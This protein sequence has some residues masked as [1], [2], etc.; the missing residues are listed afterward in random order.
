MDP[1]RDLQIIKEE[2][3]LKDI[4]FLEGKV[5]DTD[6]KAQRSKNPDMI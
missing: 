3:Q 6:K 5:K 1:I 4:A 2:L